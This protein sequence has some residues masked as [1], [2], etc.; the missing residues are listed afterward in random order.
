MS[1]LSQFYPSARTGPTG[2]TG[3]SGPAGS[4]GPAGTPGGPGATGGPGAPGPTGAPGAPGPAGPTGASPTGPTGPAGPPGV[5]GK[6]RISLSIG[7]DVDV[8]FRGYTASDH[9]AIS[10][11][12]FNDTS[13]INRTVEQIDQ[14]LSDGQVTLTFT[15]NAPNTD[16]SF[17]A[18]VVNGT[19]FPR[20]TGSFSGTRS[21]QWAGPNP[22]WPNGGSV[23]FDIEFS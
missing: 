6:R 19:R 13:G 20:S 17:K 10:P 15:D 21:W 23:V 5:A 3:P 4:P 22:A 16:N 14:R 18:I 11:S 12:T 7:I 1:N 2:A 8:L 9:G